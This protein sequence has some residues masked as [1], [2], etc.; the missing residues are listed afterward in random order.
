MNELLQNAIQHGFDEKLPGEKAELV[1]RF[2]A[3]AEFFEV[4]V[5]DNGKGLPT[6]FNEKS[7]GLGLTIVRN[8]IETDLGG[9]MELSHNSPSGTVAR[10]R[11]PQPKEELN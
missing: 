10:I 7:Y 6:Q 11:I 3:D 8:L 9:D 2:D 1:I 4:V 5:I